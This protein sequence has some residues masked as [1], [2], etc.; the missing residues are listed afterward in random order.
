M[1]CAMGW[2]SAQHGLLGGT[3]LLNMVVYWLQLY[4]STIVSHCD[5]YNELKK[6]P[7]MC[8]CVPNMTKCC[9]NACSGNT[10]PVCSLM[11]PLLIKTWQDLFASTCISGHLFTYLFDRDTAVKRSYK[12]AADMSP[13]CLRSNENDVEP[14]KIIISDVDALI[15]KILGLLEH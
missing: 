9:K 3:F 6:D 15:G 10:D 12:L 1:H 2:I 11:N 4:A 8:Q 5:S 7:I 13:K 14:K